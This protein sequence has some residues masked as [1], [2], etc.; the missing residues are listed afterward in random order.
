MCF[1]HPIN[2]MK[3]AILRRQVTVVFVISEH[4]SARPVL[5]YGN[6]IPER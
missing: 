5:Y 6:F 4:P 2:V 3:I 1:S